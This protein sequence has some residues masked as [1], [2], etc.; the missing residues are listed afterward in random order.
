MQSY[1]PWRDVVPPPLRRTILPNGGMPSMS[2]RSN[3]VRI[4]RLQLRTISNRVFVSSI[5]YLRKGSPDNLLPSFTKGSQHRPS[6]PVRINYLVRGIA[7][8]WNACF[9]YTKD[10]SVGQMLMRITREPG[11]NS[12]RADAAELLDLTTTFSAVQNSSVESRMVS[13]GL[14]RTPR[15][16]SRSS[17]RTSS[18]ARK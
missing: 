16:P 17:S 15:L 2:L 1:R 3:K 10:I 18:L 14:T 13:V 4:Y 6:E 5:I 9:R 7:K 11:S 12:T 8:F